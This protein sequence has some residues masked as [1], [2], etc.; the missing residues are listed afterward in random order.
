MKIIDQIFLL[1]IEILIKWAIFSVYVKLISMSFFRWCIAYTVYFPILYRLYSIGKYKHSSTNRRREIWRGSISSTLI[2]WIQM[3]L[4]NEFFQKNNYTQ[5]IMVSWTD[6]IWK[7]K[8][9]ELHLF[10]IKLVPQLVLTIIIEL[11]RSFNSNL[12]RN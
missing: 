10:S 9:F 7:L 12:S 8:I 5:T 4:N 6:V 1:R 2:G 3:I 11:M